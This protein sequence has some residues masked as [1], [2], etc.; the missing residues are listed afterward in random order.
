MCDTVTCI[1]SFNGF[2]SIK[3]NLAHKKWSSVVAEEEEEEGRD[4]IQI[5]VLQNLHIQCALHKMIFE[6]SLS[7]CM[8]TARATE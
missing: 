8:C 1:C 7:V 6:M 3:Q 5:Y 2:N 4:A